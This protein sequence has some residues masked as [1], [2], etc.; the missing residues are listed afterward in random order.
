MIKLNNGAD[1]R[2]FHNTNLYGT[3]I[4]N[5]FGKAKLFLISTFRKAKNNYPGRI[6]PE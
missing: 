1:I 3:N 4:R 2:K 6:T 5:T